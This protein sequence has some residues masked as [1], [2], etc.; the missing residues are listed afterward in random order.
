MLTPSAW[1]HAVKRFA[2]TAGS[3]L[4]IPSAALSGDAI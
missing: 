3:F 4:G 1:D 2:G